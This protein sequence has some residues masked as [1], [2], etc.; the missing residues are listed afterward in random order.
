ML[1]PFTIASL[2]MVLAIVVVGCLFVARYRD[3]YEKLRIPL[4]VAT[5]AAGLI[6]YSIGYMPDAVFQG[7]TG[8]DASFQ[9]LSFSDYGTIALRALFSA[10]RIFVLENDFSDLNSFVIQDR[11]YVM[12]FFLVHIL[13]LMVTVLTIISL[14]GARFISRIQLLIARPTEI[15]VFFGYDEPSQELAKSLRAGG[16]NRCICVIDSLSRREDDDIFLRKLRENRC[17]LIDRDPSE[18]DGLRKMRLPAR[19]FRRKLGIFLMDRDEDANF[20]AAENLIKSMKKEKR[21]IDS[22][23]LYIQS[24]SE[25]DERVLDNIRREEG[26][27][28]ECRIFS[29]PDLAAR[30]LMESCPIIDVM[31]IDT[32]TATVRSDFNLFIAGFGPVGMEVFRKCLYN[33]Q[34]MG[35]EF[36]AIITDG[37]MKSKMGT[38]NNRYS[39]IAKN[40]N[41]RYLQAEPGSSAFFRAITE[42]IG[43]L[44]YIVVALEDDKLSFEIAVEIDRLIRRVCPGR[45]ITLAAYISTPEGYSHY[46]DNSFSSCIRIFGRARDLFTETVIINESMDKMARTI[47]EFFNRTYQCDPT[48]N[49]HS[50]DAFT[51]ESNRSAAMNIR[52]KLRLMGLDLDDSC[53]PGQVDLADYLKGLRLE[54]LAKQEHLRWNAFHF[55]SGWTTWELED[56]TGAKKAK[57]SA[58]KR[59]ACL[60]PWDR[61]SEVTERFGQKPSYEELDID[62]VMHI[63]DI[64][65]AAG[66][67]ACRAER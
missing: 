62:Q 55:A 2:L 10:C 13:G 24:S 28:V 50:L 36:N 31:D 45:K 3:L 18:V 51:K 19:F 7:D 58:N 1:F 44:N 34:F 65:A 30:Q 48:D 26:I 5:F 32:E 4:A 56:T 49:W 47:N 12:A 64:L 20:K 53:S 42:R 16:K 35:G 43:E 22:I 37:A 61:L 33:G 46:E 39:A 38:F 11:L 25:S 41:V 15:Y 21:P 63:P 59:H 14:L 29:I 9:A 23:T 8:N 6:I 52:T 60:V 27:N 67:A 57:D 40:Y 17:I 66:K 54:N